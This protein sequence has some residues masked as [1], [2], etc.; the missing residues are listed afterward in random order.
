MYKSKLLLLERLSIQYNGDCLI[1]ALVDGILIS[2]S[3]EGSLK[4]TTN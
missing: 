2:L 3:R 1:L 4:A